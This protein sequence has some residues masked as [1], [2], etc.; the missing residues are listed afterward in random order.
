MAKGWFLRRFCDGGCRK[1]DG[2]CDGV[3]LQEERIFDWVGLDIRWG[4]V[5]FQMGCLK[6]KGVFGGYDMGWGLHNELGNEVHEG[7][8]GKKKG[9][10]E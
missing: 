1:S 3:C 10:N 9:F 5:G 7:N 6:G 2:V 8:L 4:G